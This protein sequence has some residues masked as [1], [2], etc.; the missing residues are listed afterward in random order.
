MKKLAV[1]IGAML[2]SA[3][4]GASTITNYVVV[5]SNIY[6]RIS[7]EHWITNNIKNSHTDYFFTNH[8]HTVEHET[9]VVSKTNLS[10]NLD[11]SQAAIEAARAQA[12]RA[13]SSVSNAQEFASA[14]ASA[15]SAASGAASSASSSASQAAS[16]RSAAASECAAALRNINDRIAWFDEHSGETITIVDNSTNYNY[17]VYVPEQDYSY[18]YM[19]AQ[20]N[21][22]SYVTIHPYNVNGKVWV[23]AQSSAKYNTVMYRAWPRQRLEGHWDFYP[24]YVDSDEYGMRIQYLP[25]T[26]EPIMY[27]DPESAY[28]T[29]KQVPEYFYWQNGYIYFKVRVWVDGKVVAWCISRYR[30][31]DAGTAGDPIRYPTTINYGSTSG[32]LMSLVD[33]ENYGPSSF[34]Q[35]AAFYSVTREDHG[36]A[37]HISGTVL[38]SYEPTLAWMRNGPLVSDLEQ[39]VTNVEEHV[40]WFAEKIATNEA[41]IATFTNRVSTF[42]ERLDAIES[43]APRVYV[44]SDGVRYENIIVY[45]NGSDN[46]KAAVSTVGN[47][48]ASKKYRFYL[49]YGGSATDNY[50]TFQPAYVDTDMLG[51]RLHYLPEQQKT[52]SSATDP[53]C[54]YIPRDFYWQNG[55]IY[56]VVDSYNGSTWKGTLKMKYSQ[57]GFPNAL[58]GDN[59]DTM[60]AYYVHLTFQSRDGEIMGTRVVAGDRYGHMKTSEGQYLPTYDAKLWFPEKP[61]AEQQQVLDWL[62]RWHK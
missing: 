38:P 62:S 60:T 19:D 30:Y 59:R 25:T 29:G 54:Q 2:A 40:L 52:Y 53:D 35:S 28:P 33:R 8:T 45:A 26:T 12:D 13:A 18:P 5:V 44:D 10:V 34:N 9:L 43:G 41:V 15:A 39:R 21:E 23:S 1:L 58:Y 22:Y 42:E 24:A 31:S 3:F 32:K 56:M 37:L 7:E 14:S 36:V 17:V 16:Q 55:V 61:T 49:E 20:S 47:Y 50:W 46:G 57:P 48:H 4:V 11:V 51:M 27:G 6:N